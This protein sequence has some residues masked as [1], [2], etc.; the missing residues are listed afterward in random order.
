MTRAYFVA[1]FWVTLSLA[2]QPAA[3][4]AIDPALKAEVGRL[5]VTLHIND[6]MQQQMKATMPS[7][8]TMLKSNPNV[9]PQFADEFG[10]R[11]QA[12]ILK[13]SDLTDMV[14]QAYASRFTLA[15]IKDLEAFY[16]TPTG[17]KMVDAQ[18][19]LMADIQQKAAAFGQSLALRISSE[20]VKDHPDYVKKEG[21]Q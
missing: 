12:E 19:Q 18:P 6:L 2:Q 17:K 1:I 15:E 3:S 5:L 21:A 20:I 13:S 16:N 11:F 14:V 4:P 7:V 8:I 10:K 9:T